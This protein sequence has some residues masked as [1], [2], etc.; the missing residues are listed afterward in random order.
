VLETFIAWL[1]LAGRTEQVTTTT[2]TT[3]NSG[4]NIKPDAAVQQES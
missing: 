2:T 4:S 1:I 3:D